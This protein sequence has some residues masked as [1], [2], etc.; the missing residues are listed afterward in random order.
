MDFRD[1]TFFVSRRE[2]AFFICFRNQKQIKRVFICPVRSWVRDNMANTKSFHNKK[3]AV[4]YVH[5]A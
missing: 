5:F 2:T 1:I 4:N 3:R